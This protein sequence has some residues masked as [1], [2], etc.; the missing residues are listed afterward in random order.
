MESLAWSTRLKLSSAVRRVSSSGEPSTMILPQGSMTVLWP[1][2]MMP[3]ESPTALMAAMKS[4]FSMAR[5]RSRVRQ[6]SNLTK[7][8]SAVIR[9]RWAPCKA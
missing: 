8:H 9:M 3:F 2:M 1:P 7:G 5:A 4:W 6:C